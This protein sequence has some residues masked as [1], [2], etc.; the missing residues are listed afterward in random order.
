MAGGELGN[1]GGPEGQSGS[2]L[3]F[4]LKGEPIPQKTEVN[5]RRQTE[6]SRRRTTSLLSDVIRRIRDWKKVDHVEL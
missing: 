4:E 3:Y 6:K 2:M 5:S 1:G